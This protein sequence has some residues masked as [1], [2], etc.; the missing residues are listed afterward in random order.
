[1]GIYWEKKFIYIQWMAQTGDIKM[2]EKALQLLSSMI[3][4]EKEIYHKKL[5]IA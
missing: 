5:F 1:M 2:R 3:N 4:K